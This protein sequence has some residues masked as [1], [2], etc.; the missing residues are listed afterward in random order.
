[1]EVQ[2][3]GLPVVPLEHRPGVGLHQ[4]GVDAQRGGVEVARRDRLEDDAQPQRH[5]DQLGGLGLGGGPVAGVA[6]PQ[7]L[8]GGRGDVGGRRHGPAAPLPGGQ[9]VDQPHGHLDDPIR[10]TVEVQLTSYAFCLRL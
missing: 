10:V 3:P 4:Q 9:A 7:A 6:D 2:V 5:L 1:V 8:G